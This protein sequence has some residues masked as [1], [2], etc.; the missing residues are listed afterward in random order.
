MELPPQ[1]PLIQEV[2][3]LQTPASGRRIVSW[4]LFVLIIVG[5]L[6]APLW[7]FHDTPPSPPS[8]T[9]TPGTAPE[10]A[11]EMRTPT[12]GWKTL[13]RVW[14]PGTLDQKHHAWS[15]D[16][17]ACHSAPFTRVQ[18]KDCQACH[19]RIG[20]HVATNAQA[21][22]HGPAASSGPDSLRCATCHRDHWGEFGLTQQN[23][24][25]TQ[26]RCA[27]CHQDIRASAP[28]TPTESVR[29]FVKDHPEFRIQITDPDHP[30][31]L[32]RTRMQASTPLRSASGHKFPHDV[33]LDPKGVDSPDG[34]VKV[35]CQDCHRPSKDQSTFE[36]VRFQQDCRSC[37][38]M[39]F[40]PAVANR[41]IPHGSVDQVLSTLREFYGFMKSRPP[42]VVRDQDKP[43]LALTRPG[44]PDTPI[45][46]YVH[47][48]S[49]D[50]QTASAAATAVFEKTTCVVCHEPQRVAGPGRSGTTGHDMPQW[51]IPSMTPPHAWMPQSRF[52]HRTHQL[53][54]CKTCHAAEKSTQASD[55]LMPGLAVCRD[56]HAP[57]SPAAQ[58]ASSDCGTCHSFHTAAKAPLIRSTP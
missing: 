41:E 21:Q 37:H 43:P 24:L 23:K 50:L 33:H 39:R 44:K 36:P 55:V 14:N 42:I 27:T 5:C 35:T 38:E 22:P 54:E 53:T 29:D 51:T 2:K 17:R 57:T 56:C 9:G 34:K 13:D 26:S 18:D 20:P 8:H 45:R 25:F 48:T 52:N 1:D 40:D 31:K 11:T 10:V 6:A 19:Q 7:V 28:T 12:T 32:I 4:I 16:C 49:N 47:F 15:N 3:R 58:R 30:K 46:S